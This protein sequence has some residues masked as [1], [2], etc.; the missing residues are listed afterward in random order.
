[1]EPVAHQRKLELVI[2]DDEDPRLRGACQSHDARCD[3]A[4]VKAVTLVTIGHLIP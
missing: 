4:P 2:V 1:V 3:R